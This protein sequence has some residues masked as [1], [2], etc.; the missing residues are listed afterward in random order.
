MAR[1]VTVTKERI[2]SAAG[3]PSGFSVGT[4][5]ARKDKHTSVGLLQSVQIGLEL[6]LGK[7]LGMGLYTLFGEKRGR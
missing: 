6:T 7:L 1:P 3:H 5:A 4:A 2:L